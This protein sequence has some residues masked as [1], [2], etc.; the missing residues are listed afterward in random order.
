MSRL[1]YAHHKDFIAQCKVEEE[2]I[3]LEIY[4]GDKMVSSTHRY[5]E[6]MGLKPP[7]EHP[8]LQKGQ[9]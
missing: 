3:I 6:E 2:G 8:E 9:S 5:Y 4:K 1:V 7:K